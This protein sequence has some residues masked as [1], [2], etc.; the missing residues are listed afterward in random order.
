M[1]IASALNHREPDRATTIT[2]TIVPRVASSWMSRNSAESPDP[3][4]P[5]TSHRR[6]RPLTIEPINVVRWSAPDEPSTW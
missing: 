3:M 4:L 2:R 5:M 1:T 6:A